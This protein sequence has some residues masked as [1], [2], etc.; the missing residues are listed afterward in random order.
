MI[1]RSGFIYYAGL[2][3]CGV[4]DSGIQP[5]QYTWVGG[6]P[7]ESMA[8]FIPPVEYQN[9]R[10]MPP[11]LEVIYRSGLVLTGGLHVLQKCAHVRIRFKQK[12]LEFAGG[13]FTNLK[14]VASVTENQS[15]FESISSVFDK[16]GVLSPYPQYVHPCK[17][18]TTMTLLQQCYDEKSEPQS[19]IDV[20]KVFDESFTNGC[21]IIIA[22]MRSQISVEMPREAVTS[23]DSLAVQLFDECPQRELPERYIHTISLNRGYNVRQIEIETL[24]GTEYLS[25]DKVLMGSGYD[26]PTSEIHVDKVISDVERG[27]SIEEF[28]GHNILYQF[29]FNPGVNS[30]IIVI[31][32]TATNLCVWDPSIISM[33]KA[34]IG[35]TVNTKPLLLLKCYRAQ[36]VD[37]SEH[38][39]VGSSY[40]VWEIFLFYGTRFQLLGLVAA[41]RYVKSSSGTHKTDLQRRK[42]QYNTNSNDIK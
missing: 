39:L 26:I 21:P 22:E 14:H 25:L 37:F 19:K 12:G 28:S 11:N 30:F 16:S 40:N 36:D 24:E 8:D 13:R 6:F 35:Y 3:P 4:S 10:G 23:T 27:K 2:E 29:P 1:C 34:L 15:P 7:A 41:R 17:S 20:H 42:S 33:S 32:K 38:V 5:L 31:H 9:C 18:N